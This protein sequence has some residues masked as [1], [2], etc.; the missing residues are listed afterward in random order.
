MLLGLYLVL[1][2]ETD[3]DIG[4]VMLHPLH[5]LSTGGAILLSGGCL[6]ITADLS[7]PLETVSEPRPFGSMPKTGQGPKIAPF[8]SG[9]HLVEILIGTDKKPLHQVLKPRINP[10]DY[11]RRCHSRFHRSGWMCQNIHLLVFPHKHDY[12]DQQ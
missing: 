2:T 5:V 4:K 12:R 3:L 9:P 6:K 11:L 7:H 8:Q 10:L 1:F